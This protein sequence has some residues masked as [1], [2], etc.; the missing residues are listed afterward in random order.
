VV[1]RQSFPFPFAAPSVG[2]RPSNAVTIAVAASVGVHVAVAAYLA[3]QKFRPAPTE[4]V[5]DERIIEVP[6]VDWRKPDPPKPIDR[7]ENTVTPRPSPPVDIPIAD[8]I[9]IPPSPEVARDTTARAVDVGPPP[10]PAFDPAPPAT[11]VILDPSWLRKP[12]ARDYERFYPETAMRR[13]LGG[14]T[15][16]NCRV[17]A[18]GAVTD[19]SVAA[20]TP[21]GA[22]FGPA[23]LR[24]SAYFRMKPQTEDGR[25]V[26]GAVV[27]IPI[28]FTLAD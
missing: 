11:P 1:I 22:G 14:R 20:E 5:V 3:V 28:T 4:P 9:P 26:D 23:A 7:P 2:R 18:A 25:P 8:S 24:L 12:G 10:T 27:R 17:T 15:I 21:P 16:L 13:S 19:C 6:I